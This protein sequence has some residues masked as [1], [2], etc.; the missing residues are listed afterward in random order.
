MKL[1]GRIFSHGS[2][3]SILSED[4]EQGHEPIHVGGEGV[5]MC[6]SGACNVQGLINIELATGRSIT[7]QEINLTY[8]TQAEGGN[9]S[10]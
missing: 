5:E 3:S 8:R 4:A 10:K 9:P 7:C 2:Y 6:S 1:L